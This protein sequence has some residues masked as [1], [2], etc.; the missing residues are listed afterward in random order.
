MLC[1]PLA[2]FGMQ[3]RHYYAFSNLYLSYFS[4]SIMVYVSSGGIVHAVSYGLFK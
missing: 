1:F 4:L 2:P 3:S